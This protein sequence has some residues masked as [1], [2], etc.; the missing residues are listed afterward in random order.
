MKFNKFYAAPV[1]AGLLI[2]GCGQSGPLY[3]K[4]YAPTKTTQGSMPE[5]PNQTTTH[6]LN[7][8]PGVSSQ[9]QMSSNQTE[10]QPIVTSQQPVA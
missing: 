9:N 8:T 3:I 6:P 2:A 1:L 4:A 7:P 5:H 10:V